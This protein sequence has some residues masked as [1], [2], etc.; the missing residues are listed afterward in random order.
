MSFLFLKSLDKHQMWSIDLWISKHFWLYIAKLAK[1]TFTAIL[2]TTEYL[3]CKIISQNLNKTFQYRWRQWS[4]KC[5]YAKRREYV[6]LF[7][8]LKVNGITTKNNIIYCI[9]L[10]FHKNPLDS[11]TES[12]SLKL[13]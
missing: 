11:Y 6:I 12:L 13:I 10:Q 2:I 8:C 1:L 3:K 4:K 7:E 5:F 9:K